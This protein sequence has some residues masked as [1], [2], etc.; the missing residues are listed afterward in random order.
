MKKEKLIKLFEK[1]T[2]LKEVGKSDGKS[3]MKRSKKT[4][5]T[6]EQIKKILAPIN[7]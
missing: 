3:V 4:V 7:N 5:F 6:L 1:Q 2:E